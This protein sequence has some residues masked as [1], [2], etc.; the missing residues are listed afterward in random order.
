MSKYNPI[1]SRSSGEC[2]KTCVRFLG[3]GDC[4]AA[5]TYYLNV[6]RNSTLADYRRRGRQTGGISSRTRLGTWNTK[7]IASAVLITKRLGGP[8]NPGEERARHR[9]HSSAHGPR[10]KCFMLTIALPEGR[11]VDLKQHPVRIFLNG[12]SA[13]QTLK[14][15]QQAR[16]HIGRRGIIMSFLKNRVDSKGRGKR[17]ETSE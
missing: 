8:S 9:F 12:G 6:L 1:Q 2:Y 10:R 16:A 17:Y 3:L 5:L 4:R 15:L 14:I 7:Q 11:L 13:V